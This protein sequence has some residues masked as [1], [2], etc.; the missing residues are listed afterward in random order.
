MKIVGS[1]MNR[2]VTVFMVTLAA[3]IFGLVALSRL[4]LNLLPDISYPTLT[5]Q[6]EYT[7]AAPSEVEKLI[8]ESLEEAVSV[9]PGLRKLRSIS[10]P[11]VSEIL[12]EFAWK[13]DMDFASLDV[14]EKLDMVRLP[15][16]A[17]S[18]VLLRYDPTL[19]PILRLGLYGDLE[20]APL[21]H[22]AERVI[23]K[24]LESL[25]G[26]ASVRLRGGLEEEIHV[27]V[28]EGR[29]SSLDLPIGVISQFLSNQNLNSAGGRIRD[30]DAEFLVRT[31]NE[32]ED[33]ND[34]RQTT[35]FEEAGRIV[36]LEDV[37]R[38]TRDFKEREIISRVAGKEAVELALYKEGNANTVQ[39]ARRTKNR[40][41]AL[42]EDLPEGIELVVLSDQS[43]FIEQSLN[44]VRNNALLGGLLAVF[45]LF[46][47]LKD[48]RST[49]IIALVIPTSIMATFFVMQQFNVSLNIM[50]LGG[51]ALGVG[52]LVDNAIVVLEAIGRQK[53][54][55][56]STW[57]ATV[58][59]ASEVSQAVTASTLT[60]VAVFLPIIFVEGIAGQIFRDQALTVAASLVVSLIAALT[61]IPVL[62]SIG[63]KRAEKQA[64]GTLS[65]SSD[66]DEVMPT[67]DIATITDSDDE[68]EGD[69]SLIERIGSVIFLPLRWLA[70]GIGFILRWTFKIITFPFR[71]LWK[72]LSRPL[73]AVGRGVQ[74]LLK[75]IGRGLLFFLFG[76][77]VK[78]FGL[79]FRGLFILTDLLIFPLQK[80][81]DHFWTW[82]G[83]V[84]PRVIRHALGHRFGTVCLA[85]LLAVGCL[86]LT[87]QLGVELV[88]PFSQG[89][90]TFDLEL[91]P[92]TPLLAVEGKVASVEQELITDGNIS[93]LF[94]SV[95][96]SPELGSA[97]SERRENIAQLN[98]TIA[99]TG[100]RT[101]ETAVIE[102]C[103]RVLDGHPE[104]R[105]TFRR[106]SYFSF[107]TPV[108]VQVFGYNL[109][110][111]RLYANQLT[112]A[113][114]S[115]EGLRDLRNS[116]ED[117]NPEVQV[118]FNRER[119]AALNL[120]LEAVS[121]VLRGKIHGD[122]ATRLKEEDRQIDIRVRTASA[123]MIEVDDIGELVVSQSGGVPI[124]LTTVAD[125]Q[126]G[127][128]P[129]QITHI[130]QQRA[131][132]ISANLA[133][134]DLGS[135]SREI[136][137]LLDRM[138]APG[139]MAVT[140]GGQN[141]E[142]STSFRSLLL[143]AVLAVFMVYL[144]MASQFESFLH[145]FVILMTVPL[146]LVGIILA[147]FLTGTSVSI[148]VL[149]GAVM[150]TGIVVNN[151]IVLIDFINQRRRA[152]LAKRQAILEA[153]SARLR[154]ILMTTLT[155]ILG[156]L[157]MAIGLGEGAEI[158]A[159]MAIAVIGGLTVATMLTLVV[160]P[161]VYDLLDRKA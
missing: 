80:M 63:T 139:N 6:T 1:S 65:E 55:G 83:R 102:R 161:V 34:I 125:V 28:D 160:I 146:G 103:R 85:L 12:L 91:P 158:R 100:D 18:P 97:R 122:V 126:L 29:L 121:R 93:T 36:K 140:L 73:R 70:K 72:L 64:A 35:I 132:V 90:F 40:L 2:P 147:L 15:D 19:D 43:V 38:I 61:L 10:R 58:T 145:P 46:L 124:T 118:R 53:G 25:D 59:G 52:M 87:P 156:L 41:D 148:V 144:V 45:V 120:D 92:G 75:W 104:I 68:P 82:L 24:D 26:V 105:Y 78:F 138:P 8:T 84:Y 112:E 23:K 115:I 133:G 111:M 152:G 154:P 136:Q 123:E 101:M 89:S 66:E 22:L 48:R 119:L 134:R 7:D 155:T 128:G 99:D 33:I 56:K 157:P 117:G 94:S 74:W 127:I 131:A 30:R 32:F 109:E 44:E 95:G 135:A 129:A 79:L 141:N 137:T 57:D 11:G 142:I 98:I 20:L 14:R 42:R 31:L 153:A 51:L 37:A 114:S 71:M 143:A 96:D 76:I 47:F 110:A 116:L 54:L 39:V 5:I 88:P 62:A 113:M 67:I 108:E 159:P 4:S 107:S 69:A 77:L 17:G 86:L 149:I 16:D 151:A 9:I 27:E 21:R 130:G 106:P 50:S 3:V 49:A 13:T 81:F 150:L 60:T